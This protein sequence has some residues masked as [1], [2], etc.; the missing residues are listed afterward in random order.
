MKF[1]NYALFVLLVLSYSISSNNLEKVLLIINYNFAH[2]ESIP[3]LKKIYSSTFK[4]IV[5]YGPEHYDDVHYL[6]HDGGYVSYVA[7]VDAMKKYPDFDGYLFLMDDCILNTWLLKNMDTTKIW[8]GEISWNVGMRGIKIPLGLKFNAIDWTFWRSEYGF[9]A[10]NE[11][12]NRLPMRYREM[13]TKNIG[14][15][16]VKAHYSDIAYIPARLRDQFIEVGT[17]FGEQRGFLETAFPTILASIEPE[18]DWV[19]LVGWGIDRQRVIN[20][21]RYDVYFN[22]PVK[23]SYS[24]NYQFIDAL[25]NHV[26]SQNM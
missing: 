9:N 26:R 20:S 22:H 21:F 18:S 2:Y 23:L 24:E 3:L 16:N 19:W 10:M 8:F 25:F 15:N 4:N 11:A 5:F 7:V 13:L 6:K 1:K 17:I 14:P 12:F